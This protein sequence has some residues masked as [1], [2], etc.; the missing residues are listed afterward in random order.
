MTPFMY[1]IFCNFLVKQLATS[2][3]LIK[4][5]KEFG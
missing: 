4:R 1:K 5:S 2:K 3:S